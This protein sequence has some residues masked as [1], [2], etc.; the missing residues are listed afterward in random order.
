MYTVA[1]SG[2]CVGS[3]SL[4][5]VGASDVWYLRKARQGDPGQTAWTCYC[6]QPYDT[7]GKWTTPIQADA[8]SA[9]PRCP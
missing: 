1:V 4:R 3:Q 7:V 8:R 2:L 5:G 9:L 6:T